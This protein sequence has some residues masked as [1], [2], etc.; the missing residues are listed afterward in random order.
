MPRRTRRVRT[1]GRSAGPSPV[2]FAGIG[3]LLFGFLLISVG[4]FAPVQASTLYATFSTM[5]QDVTTVRFFSIGGV[6]IPMVTAYDYIRDISYSTTNGVLSLPKGSYIVKSP[7][8]WPVILHLYS[9]GE[10]YVRLEPLPTDEAVEDVLGEPELMKMSMLDLGN[11]LTFA[12]IQP[13][14]NLMEFAKRYQDRTAKEAIG[15]LCSLSAPAIGGDIQGVIEGEIEGVR[16][17]FCVERGIYRVQISYNVFYFSE[18]GFQRFIDAVKQE[19][20]RLN[21]VFQEKLKNQTEAAGNKTLKIRGFKGIDFTVTREVVDYPI[22]EYTTF[23]K[24]NEKITGILAEVV[25]YYYAT[26]ERDS[27]LVAQGK[28]ADLGPLN[29]TWPK[30]VKRQTY[31]GPEVGPPNELQ[32]AVKVLRLPAGYQLTKIGIDDKVDLPSA[33]PAFT[34][35]YPGYDAY[36]ELH[37][38][39]IKTYYITIYAWPSGEDPSQYVI[40]V[41]HI[42]GRLVIYDQSNPNVDPEN[43]PVVTN[44][45]ASLVVRRPPELV[46]INDKIEE[47]GYFDFNIRLPK[48]DY[49]Y[50]YT[51]YFGSETV[52]ITVNGLDCSV[53]QGPYSRAKVLSTDPLII[54]IDDNFAHLI[55]MPPFI[56]TSNIRMQ[57]EVNYNSLEEWRRIV[58]SMRTEQGTTAG[59]TTMTAIS[60]VKTINVVE[61]TN[62]D[63]SKEKVLT[64]IPTTKPLDNN[65]ATS[66]LKPRGTNSQI[67]INTGIFASIAGA[68]MSVAGF[69]PATRLR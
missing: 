21:K 62:P 34:K 5:G 23:I 59:I 51:I 37:L 18:Q 44:A 10:A 68:I 56:G 36:G 12:L 11:F 64:D 61:A 29:F 6:S 4:M 17:R 42:R 13:S 57:G 49:D 55:K 46:L 58:N 32:V 24:T 3:L 33:I 7:G 22:I 31:L 43:L 2:F 45:V 38:S 52:T 26:R 41:C 16:Y 66:D 28:I 50:E 67:F 63:G 48:R 9:D 69:L 65:V 54:G 20:E 25:I 14:V 1:R 60:P 30:Y 19:R 40:N 47:D 27:F 53:R 35:L 39:P 8:F 15:T